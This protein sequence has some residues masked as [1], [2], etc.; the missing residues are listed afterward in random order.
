MMLSDRTWSCHRKV[1]L[2]TCQVFR[3]RTVTE[4]NLLKHL[5]LLKR[6]KST[7][8]LKFHPGF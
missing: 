4:E 1:A 7:V 2:K 5:K 3:F 6:K 8:L